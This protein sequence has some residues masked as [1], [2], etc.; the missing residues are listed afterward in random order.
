[1]FREVLGCFFKDREDVLY[2]SIAGLGEEKCS[3]PDLSYVCSE[4]WGP[5]SLFLNV[6]ISPCVHMSKRA[7]KRKG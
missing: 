2:R 6:E 3:E 4:L 7:R 5:Q 1:M